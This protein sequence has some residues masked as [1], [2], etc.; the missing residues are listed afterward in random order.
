LRKGKAVRG[1]EAILERADGTRISVLPYPT[2]IRDATGAIVGVINMTV[3]I[4]ERKE[5]ENHKNT[6]ISE[7]DHRVKNVLAIVSTV[8]SRTQETSSSMSEFV[9][10]LDGRIKSMAATHELLSN[11]RWRGIPLIELA[12]RVLAPYVTANNARVDGPDV[13]LSAEAGQTLATVL[14]ELASNAAKFGAHFEAVGILFGQRQC[15]GGI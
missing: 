4:T 15:A 6:L 9:S 3:D 11:R 5:L 8:A 10:A 1:C 7:L 13:M 12:R 14:H 2:P